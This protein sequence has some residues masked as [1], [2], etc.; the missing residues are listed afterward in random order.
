MDRSGRVMLPA[1]LRKAMALD[2][3]DRFTVH[4]VGDRIELIPDTA[5]L[6]MRIADDGLPI[7]VAEGASRPLTNDEVVD[8]VHSAREERLDDLA[9][10]SP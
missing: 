3:G 7:L 8:G 1:S 6:E 5:D 9:G 2:P 10:T 4:R